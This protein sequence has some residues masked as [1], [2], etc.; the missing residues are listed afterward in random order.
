MAKDLAIDVGIP[1]DTDEFH[2]FVACV[3]NIL[4]H[5]CGYGDEVTDRIVEKCHTSDLPIAKKVLRECRRIS[6]N[7]SGIR[8]SKSKWWETYY[9]KKNGDVP[10]WPGR[11]PDR[12]KR[13]MSP[14]FDK[15]KRPMSPMFDKR[16]RGKRPMSPM[17]DKRKRGQRNDYNDGRN[18]YN[19]GGNDYNDGRNERNDRRNERNDRRNYRNDGRNSKYVNYREDSP[20]YERNSKK[21]KYR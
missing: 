5:G 6:R 10:R 12:V 8:P 3:D 1:V 19:D 4:T 13:P 17:F 15:R 20:C 7:T 9:N 2:T 18:D 21:R 11:K 16:K 14:M